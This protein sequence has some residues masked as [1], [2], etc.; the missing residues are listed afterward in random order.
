[1]NPHTGMP[2]VIA[3]TCPTVRP[4][5]PQ[6]DAAIIKGFHMSMLI[7]ELA[8]DRMREIQRDFEHARR[9]RLARA[10]RRRARTGR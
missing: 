10:V 8:R 3:R 7:E 1:M 2:G 9:V 5:H 4:V 6:P